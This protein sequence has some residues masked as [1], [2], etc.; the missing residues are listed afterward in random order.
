[1]ILEK[2]DQI[3]KEIDRAEKEKTSAE[4]RIDLLK[5]QMERE[6]K[7]RDLKEAMALL[8]DMEEELKQKEAS[9]QE[10][11]KRLQEDVAPFMR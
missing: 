8:S 3:Q 1:M 11:F 7:T 2:I 4:S 5:D 6:F 10:A 9:F